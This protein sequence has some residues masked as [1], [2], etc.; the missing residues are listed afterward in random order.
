MTEYTYDVINIFPKHVKKE[1]LCYIGSAH[2][3]INELDIDIRGVYFRKKKDA[4][5][6]LLPTKKTIDQN[7]NKLI[8][9][10]VM[11]F[12]SKERNNK[13][14]EDIKKALITYAKNNEE[15]LFK[16]DYT[17][18]TFSIRPTHSHGTN[19]AKVTRCPRITN[20]NEK[21]PIRKT[22]FVR[23]GNHRNESKAPRLGVSPSSFKDFKPSS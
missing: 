16:K 22:S 5:W 8:E 2:I 17:D 4:Y 9:F 7:T 18:P 19:R 12:A 14:K 23:K 3:Y 11:Q 1:T 15:E 21:K 10:P 13:F 20:K 6:V